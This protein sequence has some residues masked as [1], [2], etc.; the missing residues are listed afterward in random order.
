M[1]RNKLQRDRLAEFQIIGP[2]DFTHSAA[3]KES[4]NPIALREQRSWYKARI[5]N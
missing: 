2:I 5:V 3:T 4:N 1:I